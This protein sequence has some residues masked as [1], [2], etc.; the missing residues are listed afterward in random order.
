MKLL[1]L[2]KKIEYSF[3]DKNLLK[4]ALT[5]RSYLNENPKWGLSNNER[6]EFLGDA[7]LELAVTEELYYRYPDYQEG[8]MTALRSALVNYQALADTAKKINLDDFVLLSKGEARG[9]ERAK[10]VILANTTEAL[11]GAIYL[12]AD[13]QT[14]KK[15]VSQF[16][17][18]I[19]GEVLKNK[20]YR[21][22]KSLL[23]EKIQAAKKITPDYRVLEESGPE[24]DKVFK[25]GV[26]FQKKLIATG[27]GYSKQEAELDAAGKALQKLD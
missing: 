26:Y 2:E 24:H 11:I 10:E 8:K 16:V 13:Y 19:L 12:D 5:H 18:S 15:F 27:E 4:E 9:G 17:V 1:K 14:A 23:Q 25:V 6:L 20:S 21:D 22:A 7:V 3:K